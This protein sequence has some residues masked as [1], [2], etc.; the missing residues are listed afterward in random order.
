MRARNKTA[1]K[2]TTVKKNSTGKGS[3][4]PTKKKSSPARKKK[5]V[6]S[7]KFDE[8]IRLNKYIA[9]CGICSRRKADELIDNGEV[10]VNGK[11]VYELGVKVLPGKDKIIV[12]G[13]PI[14]ATQKNVYLML[15]KP[16]SVVTTMDD[17][18]GR[19]TVSDLI[20]G[21]AERLFPVGRLDWDSEGLLIMTNDG[22]FAQKVAHPKTEIPKTYLVKVDGQPDAKQLKKLL[23]GVTIPRGGKVKARAIERLR[24]GAGK[25][26]WIKIIIAEGK[27]RQVRHMFEKIGFDVM[28]LQR[29]AIGQ[30]KLGNLDRGQTKTLKPRDLEKVFAPVE[31]ENVLELKT[32][33]N[34]KDKKKKKK[35]LTKKTRR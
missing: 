27:N 31:F 24:R 9:D 14:K 28:K 5:K 19:P 32:D 11:K 17:P 4:A 8:K 16:K 25:Y 12:Q 26:A 33:L 13:K 15:H 2:S 23:M 7:K 10:T 6:S 18:L 29:V 21:E 35:V 30:L 1:R 3:K 20:K 34:K 22:V